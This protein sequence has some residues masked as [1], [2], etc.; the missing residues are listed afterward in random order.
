MVVG[1]VTRLT[2]SGLSIVEWQPLLG[3]L[4]P[5]SEAHW[6][7][8]LFAKY[9]QSPGVP[10]WSTSDMSMDGFKFIFWWEWAHRLVRPH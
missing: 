8:R 5:L 7:E 3:A 10:D 4:P 1:G 6:L 2:Q 9:Q